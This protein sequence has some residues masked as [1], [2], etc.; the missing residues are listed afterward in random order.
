MS[1]LLAVLVT[2][3]GLPV[4]IVTSIL[5]GIVTK[6]TCLLYTSRF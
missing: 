6:G 1:A 3:Q 5:L 4:I 2:A